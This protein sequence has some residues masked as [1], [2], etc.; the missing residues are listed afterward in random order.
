MNKKR[1][2]LGMF[3]IISFLCV[4]CASNKATNEIKSGTYIEESQGLSRIGLKDG[5]QFSFS[6]HT[7]S[8][9]LPMGTYI[10]KEDEL[11]LTDNE[12]KTYKFKIDGDK[13][14]L[15]IEIDTGIKT[16][17]E[18]KGDVYILKKGMVFSYSEENE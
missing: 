3:I 1:S 14:I 18:G 7:A 13:L 8:S 12:Q 2:I 6:L 15:D 4:G 16:G 11:I 5:N 10:L 9:Y 17:Y